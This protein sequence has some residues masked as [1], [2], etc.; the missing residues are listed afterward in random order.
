MPVE[1][2]QLKRTFH[3][4]SEKADNDDTDVRRLIGI[5]KALGWHD[6]LKHWRVGVLSEAG[7][8]KTSE[9]RHIAQELRAEGRSAFFIRLEHIGEDFES[10]FEE[11]S[12]DEFKTWLGGADE[13]WLLL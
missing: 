9:I 3:P 4:L 8:G 13:A 2:I 5:G 6:L 10:A 12:H 11:G 1:F 7:S